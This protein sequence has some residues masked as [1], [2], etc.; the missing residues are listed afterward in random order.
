MFKPNDRVLITEGEFKGREAV[1]LRSHTWVH[2]AV[3][4]RVD[5]YPYEQGFY[6]WSLSPV[7]NTPFALSVHDWIKENLHHG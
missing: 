5:D 3:I 2:N 4:A 7:G 1:V 6:T